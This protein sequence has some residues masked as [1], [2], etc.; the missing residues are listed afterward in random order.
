MANTTVKFTYQDLLTAPDD[1]NRYEIFEGELIVTP[2]PIVKHQIVSANLFGLLYNY[3]KS[4]NLG[5]LLA[6]PMDVYFNEETVVEPDLLFV[7]NKRSHILEERRINGAPDLIIEILSPG[8]AERDRGFKFRHYEKESVQEYWIADP[9]EE[10]LEIFVLQENS[11]TLFEK[12]SNND[13]VS[14]PLFS[15]LSFNLSDLWQ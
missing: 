12:F 4:N 7:S 8:T 15:E 9:E 2:S 3:I 14:P 6:A 11:F 10:T 13:V 1:G 5:T